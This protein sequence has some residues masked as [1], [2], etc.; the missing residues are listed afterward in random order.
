[1][2]KLR[3][4]CSTY[5]KTH[6]DLAYTTR[7]ICSNSFRYFE[8][9]VG[10]KLITSIGYDDAEAYRNWLRTSGRAKTTTNIYTRALGPVFG[11]AVKKGWLFTEWS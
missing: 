2:V 7:Q 5:L 8:L 9:A 3:K 11:W 4:L 1:M 6:P 10:D